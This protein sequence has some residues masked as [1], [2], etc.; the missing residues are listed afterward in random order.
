MRGTRLFSADTPRSRSRRPVLCI[1]HSRLELYGKADSVVCPLAIA[2]AA[3]TGI[4]RIVS[5]KHWATD[6][7]AGAALGT[8]VG[9]I[10]AL[11]HFRASATA[12]ALH[13][14]AI[15][16]RDSARLAYRRQF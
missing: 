5:N 12:A 3:G 13:L 4:L 14:T 16:D 15:V 10:V 2:A 9:T 7:L 8:A 11:S 1:Q 6:V